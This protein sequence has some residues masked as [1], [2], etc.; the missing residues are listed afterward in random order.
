[1]DYNFDDYNSFED[2]IL[3]LNYL[4]H[5][6]FLWEK[7]SHNY[8]IEGISANKEFLRKKETFIFGLLWWGKEI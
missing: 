2:Y 3:Y 5:W 8:I 1:M 4:K 6:A 7:K